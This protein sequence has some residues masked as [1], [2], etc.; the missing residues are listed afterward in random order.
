MY[1]DGPLHMA[2]QRLGN[3]PAPTG[4]SPE[5]LPE[6]MNDREGWRERVTDIR[7]DGTTK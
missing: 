5:D 2:E 7:A 1:T 3:Q 4:C 6:S